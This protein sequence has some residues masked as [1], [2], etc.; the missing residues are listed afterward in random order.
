MQLHILW[1]DFWILD[2]R[3]ENENRE[4]AIKVFHILNF[5][6]KSKEWNEYSFQIL[7]F[8]AKNTV[9]TRAKARMNFSFGAKIQNLEYL[10]QFKNN[11]KP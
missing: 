9:E 8:R 1:T 10:I 5:R 7:N 6:A 2:F 11:L 4:I 3:T